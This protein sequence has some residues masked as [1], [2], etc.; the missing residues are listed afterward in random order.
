M[1]Y[2]K[3]FHGRD[4]R[5]QGMD[6]WGYDGP[7]LGPLKHAH[8]SYGLKIHLRFVDPKR[9]DR[10][11]RIED[12]LAVFDGRYYGDWSVFDQAAQ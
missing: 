6:D 4:T 8:T 5:D 3:L 2:I 9:E 10:D 11:I 1:M 7:I 12:G